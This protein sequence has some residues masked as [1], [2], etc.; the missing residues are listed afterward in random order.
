MR[1]LARAHLRRER[2]GHTLQ[3]TALVHDTFLKLVGDGAAVS[4]QGRAHFYGIAARL[5]RRV[6]VE[7]ARARAAAKRGGGDERVFVDVA[8]VADAALGGT[9]DPVDLVALDD[10][11]RAFAAVYLRKAEVVELKFFGGLEAREIA[12]ALGTGEK[13]VLRDWAFA[14]LWLRR[15]LHPTEGR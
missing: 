6:L 4:W 9:A 1:A 10:T 7:H 2:A 15:E 5:M 8:E 3:P 11:L 12:E 13:T 14:K